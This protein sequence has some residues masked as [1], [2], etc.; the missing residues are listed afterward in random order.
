MSTA[1]EFY[2]TRAEE[3]RSAAL[4]ATLDNV[5]ERHLTAAAA[6]DAMAERGER[7][8]RERVNTEAR[9]AAAHAEAAAADPLSPAPPRPLPLEDDTDPD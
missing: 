8:E 7:T 9:K 6:W 5:R 4:A 2:R 1:N 3:A